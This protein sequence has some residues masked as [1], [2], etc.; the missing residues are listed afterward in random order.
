M[1]YAFAFETAAV[2]VGDLYFNDPEAGH[3]AEQGVRLEVRLADRETDPESIFAAA[4]I[5]LGRPVWRVDLLEA[6]DEP[7]TLDRAHHHPEFDDWEPCDREFDATMTAD[8]IEWTVDRLARL[9]HENLSEDEG[10]QIR[11]ALPEIRTAIERLLAVARAQD[12]AAD[13]PAAADEP[14]RVGWL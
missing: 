5:T 11:T 13:P 1:L 10:S 14:A 4:P 8:P 7:G 12:F 3:G 9:Q 2:V 6:V